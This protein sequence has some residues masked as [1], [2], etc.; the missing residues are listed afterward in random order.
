MRNLQ[1]ILVIERALFS[2]DTCPI[3]VPD[4][5]SGSTSPST[6]DLGAHQHQNQRKGVVFHPHR[7]HVWFIYLH[8]VDFYIWFIYLQKGGSL[9]GHFSWGPQAT[10]TGMDMPKVKM[11]GTSV[12]GW[13][14]P[15][16]EPFKKGNWGPFISTHLILLM[17]QKSGDHQL[18]LG[19]FIVDPFI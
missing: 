13:V 7:I 9:A 12:G 2:L 11:A 17:L 15:H 4:G 1:Q 18:R 5:A 14:W 6:Q 3:S 10:P 19:W 16:R 8:L